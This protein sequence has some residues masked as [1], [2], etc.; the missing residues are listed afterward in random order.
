MLLMMRT[1]AVKRHKQQL[2]QNTLVGASLAP[3]A[4][5]LL[6]YPSNMASLKS[7]MA[8]D[9]VITSQVL[10]NA[11]YVNGHLAATIDRQKVFLCFLSHN[12]T[13]LINFST[14][15]AYVAKAL[16]DPFSHFL[17]LI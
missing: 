12:S 7:K 15:V 13:Q 17:L 1:A 10:D 6:S 14:S 5:R 2:Q 3:S 9:D 8:G 4:A 16:P 11:M